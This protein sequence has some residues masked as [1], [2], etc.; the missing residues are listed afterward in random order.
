MEPFNNIT[1][2]KH[3]HTH[4]VE[5]FCWVQSTSK[6]DRGLSHHYGEGGTEPRRKEELLGNQGRASLLVMCML[7]PN[8]LL[9]GEAQPKLL[10]GKVGGEP[11]S[12]RWEA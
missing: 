3:V 10:G 8:G 5:V 12:P 6:K 7:K 1:K 2:E 11:Q 9:Q 4:Q